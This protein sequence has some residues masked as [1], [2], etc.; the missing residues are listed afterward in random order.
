MRIDRFEILSALGRGTWGATYRAL[1]TKSAQKVALKVALSRE[2]EELL[3]REHRLL[4]G[5]DH[6]GI[7][8]ALDAGDR[9]FAM[10]LVEGEI[11]SRRPPASLYEAVRVAR[12]VAL[13]LAYLHAR[14]IVHRDIKPANLLLSPQAVKLIDFGLAREAGSRVEAAEG[15]IG[16]LAPELL[17]GGEVD[18]RSDLYSLGATLYEWIAGRPPFEDPDPQRVLAMHLEAAPPS[19]RSAGPAIP[20][21]L[22]RLV[23]KLLA[24]SPTSRPASAEAVA[25]H[26]SSILDLPAVAE[27]RVERGVDLLAPPAFAGRDR[28]RRVIERACERAI[29]GAGEVVVVTGPTGSGRSRLLEE[30]QAGPWPGSLVTLSASAE[31]SPGPF[32]VFRRLLVDALAALDPAARDAAAARCGGV[33]A[34]FVPALRH[35]LPD[36]R[37]DASP[38]ELPTAFADLLVALARPAA[39]F[40][41]AVE[42]L[43]ASTAEL[44]P[45]LAQRVRRLPVLVVVSLATDSRHERCPARA[46]FA[47]M[48]REGLAEEVLLPP[49]ARAAV[50]AFVQ[51]MLGG[52]PLPDEVVERIERETGG[53]PGPIAAAVRTLVQRDLLLRKGGRWQLA[54]GR[55][56]DWQGQLAGGGATAA[57]EAISPRDEVVLRALAL[58]GGGA[59]ASV[60]RAVAGQQAGFARVTE[61][62]LSYVLHQL[63]RRGV[64]RQVGG[65]FLFVDAA[66]EEATLAKWG[67]EER[68]AA[69]ERAFAAAP[70]GPHRVRH[71]IGA[72]RHQEAIDGL[73]EMAL[74]AERSGAHAACSEACERALAQMQAA[75]THADPQAGPARRRAEALERLGRSLL[76]RGDA[77][78]AEE[79]LREALMH[80]PRGG[81]DEARLLRLLAEAAIE[82]ESLAEAERAAR[83]AAEIGTEAPD[84]E[85]ARLLLVEVLLEKGDLAQA[86]GLLDGF[87]PGTWQ[88]QL[89]GRSADHAARLA[90]ARGRWAI[91]AGEWGLAV[92]HLRQVP[93]QSSNL[94][95]VARRAKGELAWPEAGPASVG[96]SP[97][98]RVEAYVALA[99]AELARLRLAEA[100]AWLAKAEDERGRVPSW[101]RVRLDLVAA[102]HAALSGALDEAF[103]RAG[104]AAEAAASLGRPR[105]QAAA[106]VLTA[107][108]HAAR[109]RGEE[110]RRPAE[111][112]ISVA[113]KSGAR[114]LAGWGRWA[115]GECLLAKGEAIAAGSSFKKGILAFQEAGIEWPLATLYLGMARA[116]RAAGEGAQALHW[117]GKAEV[118]A[119]QVEDALTE[120]RAALLRARLGR[121]S[122]DVESRRHLLRAVEVFDRGPAPLFLAEA[123]IEEA[124]LSLEQLGPPARLDELTKTLTRAEEAFRTAGCALAA[125]RAAQLGRELTRVRSRTEGD[126]QA[127]K[128]AWLGQPAGGSVVVAATNLRNEVDATLG[129]VL[130]EEEARMGSDTKAVM[131]RVEEARVSLGEKIGELS[132]RN[133]SLLARLEAVEEERASLSALSAVGR[134]VTSLHDP[135]RVVDAIMD[136]AIRELR[137]ERGFLLLNDADGSIRFR[138]ARNLDRETVEKPESRV[139]MTVARMVMTGG[140]PVLTSDAEADERF[141]ERG[142]VSELR[143]KSILC[144]PLLSRGQVMGL[145]YVDNRF[146]AGCFTEKA[147][148]F[149]VAFSHQAA[150]AIENARLYEDLRRSKAELETLNRALNEKLSDAERRLARSRVDAATQSGFEGIV[151]ESN[152]MLELRKLVTRVAESSVP[153]VVSGES[154]AGKELVARAIHRLSPRREKPFAAVNCAAIPEGLLESEL[155]GHMKG[156]FTGADRDREGLFESADGG[157]LFLDE[158]AEMGLEM[159]KKLLRALQ[160]GEIRRV[161]GKESKRVDVRIIC[162]SNRELEP[163]VREG[164][165]RE[166]LFYRINVVKV[167]VPALRERKEDIPL[168]VSHFLKG[169]AEKAR[170]AP[171]EVTPAALKLLVMF[172]WPGNVRELENELRRADVMA[173]RAIDVGDLSPRLRGE[174]E[175]P[176]TAESDDL[177]LKAAQE[178]LERDYVTRA[179]RRTAGNRSRASQ[180]LG[181]SRQGL[182]NLIERYGLA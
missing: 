176:R 110:G 60:V 58:A 121:G 82:A 162:A 88:G 30:L 42:R 26:L 159:Q 102:A 7:V 166:D 135:D 94:S 123:A 108:L 61:L 73:L 38:D 86:K 87:P 93:D 72:G 172:P 80:A 120:G 167:R 32:E 178:R 43:D 35:R 177:D 6:P 119:D 49:F 95:P 140:E 17:R 125:K 63:V 144:A 5:L 152:P 33:I 56:R 143:L 84:R 44:L 4:T 101:T 15:T 19:P 170:R 64:L 151:G 141:R 25:E 8:R 118:A 137:A 130:K 70:P 18:P 114:P 154:G 57:E 78:G 175:G 115:A 65:V 92:S 138:A 153:V 27:T 69:H 129:R 28:E 55:E 168:L 150:I 117:L 126:W 89:A 122:G 99:R 113:E 181:L 136:I 14:R 79:R 85:A 36:P 23:L 142:S 157:T 103:R 83:R 53:Q 145:I 112:A 104:T 116:A 75:G 11:L 76:A 31:E 51:S 139:S 165:F 155:F 12:D 66:R 9:W 107:A 13:A 160:N 90:V 50:Q 39:L 98:W 24:K 173:E 97:R 147:L 54:L 62:E 20:D 134:Q 127:G 40:L 71:A 52:Q 179:L 2:G 10:E 47:R 21:P 164:K 59:P 1:D 67:R 132:E 148:D 45:V 182:I 91:Q 174:E 128:P 180:I 156:S 34:K 124:T 158:V 171:R 109:G 74:D 96:V 3:R 46:A 133:L 111:L 16:F 81:A 105:L 106:A 22:E 146:V 169:M 161:G 29:A 68:L 48:Q 37:W 41:H 100:H 149:L 77:A 131:L 163:L